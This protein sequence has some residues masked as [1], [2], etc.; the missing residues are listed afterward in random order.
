MTR[1]RS[2][3]LVAADTAP[4]AGAAVLIALHFDSGILRLCWGPSDIVVG[5]DTYYATGAALQV[6]PHAEAADGAEGLQFTL[7]GLDP[8]VLPLVIA[9]PYKGRLLQMLEQRFDADHQL[10]GS[11]VVEYVGR[12]TAM[13]SSEDPGQRSHTVTV[14][15]ETYDTEGRRPVYL[16]FSDEEQRRRYP[17]DKGAEYVTSLTERVLAR[18]P[19]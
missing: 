14:Q 1:G 8:A 4:H 9:E 10:V 13:T 12:M 16:R 2:A 19:R 11:A 5:A 7:S 17:T 3:G 18:K 15:T 6:A